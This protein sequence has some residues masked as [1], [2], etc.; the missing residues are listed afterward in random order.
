MSGVDFWIGAIATGVL[1][2]L[3]WWMYIRGKYKDPKCLPCERT[4]SP[5]DKYC[6][7]CGT[8][9]KRPYIEYK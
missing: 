2:S 1:V 6:L 8:K 7:K 5:D 3:I 9:L 4:Y